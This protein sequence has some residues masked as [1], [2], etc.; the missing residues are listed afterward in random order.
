M[1]EKALNIRNRLFMF[2]LS[3]IVGI[4]AVMGD[5]LSE[6]RTAFMNYDFELASEKYAKYAQ[7]LKKNP[8]A[9]GEE[10][11]EKYNRQLEIAEN[12]LDN[13]QKIEI[14]D[15]M[16]VPAEDFFKYIKLPSY[17]GKLMAPDI[18]L[19]K[20]RQNVSDFAFS[21]ESGDLM[22]WSETGEDSKE[23]IFQSEKLLDGTWEKPV[24]LGDILN[25]G[26]SIR[27]PFLLTDGLT[28]YFTGDGEGSMG[29]YDIFVATKDPVTEEYRQPV[30]MGFP[31]N[32]PF[33]EY[34]MAID[35]DNGIGWWVTDRNNLEGQVSVYIFKTN[36]VRKNYVLDE[37]DDIISLARVNDISI[38]Q[39][40]STDYAAILKEIDQ[41]HTQTNGQTTH[42]FIFPL[43]E[44]RVAKSLSDF[45]SAS[46]RRSMQ[47]YLEA[48]AEHDA[49]IK[50][51]SDLRKKYYNA[52]KKNGVSASLK[53]Q[54]LELES[55]IDWQADKLKKMRNTIITAEI[56]Q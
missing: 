27:N 19:L 45:T 1:S 30:S 39:N 52:D 23:H 43:P 44:G 21:T 14:I 24:M 29:G 26:G 11:L 33:N 41:R 46:A 37:E 9:I 42:D 36:D 31:F 7:S 10:L 13:V 32:S 38:T 4:P 16:D 18:S 49:E 12:S 20:K 55:K 6:G 47:Q 53:S 3:C 56:K 48:S 8:D 54:I 28:L 34:L 35:E 22:M 40:P 50:K 17:G 15:R 25:D 51:L 5:V 2:S